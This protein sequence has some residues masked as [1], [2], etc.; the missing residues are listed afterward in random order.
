M[1]TTVPSTTV[2]NAAVGELLRKVF[3]TRSPCA[4]SDPDYA[5]RLH[6]FLF[7]MTDWWEDL[8]KFGW[9]ML[10]PGTPPSKQAVSAVYGFLI[11]A[12]PHLMA[13]GEALHG[14]PITHPFTPTPPANLANGTPRPKTT[15]RPK[16]KK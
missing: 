9:A 13:A 5:S 4:P 10:E 7:H 14:E 16:V 6:D 12:V 3:D 15:R 1:T 2:P 8:A 11:H